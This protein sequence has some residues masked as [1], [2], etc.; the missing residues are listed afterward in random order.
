MNQ[1]LTIETPETLFASAHASV[2]FALACLEPSGKYLRAKSSFVDPSGQIMHWHDFGDLE[3]PGWAANAIGGAELLYRW[4]D[5]VQ[6][7]GS[8]QKALLLIDHIL[9][10]GFIQPD[11]F[12]YPYFDLGKQRFCLNYLHQD[13]WLCPGSLARIG[14]Q[15]LSLAD[16]LGEQAGDRPERL[17]SAAEKLAGWLEINVPL[18]PNGWIPRRITPDGDPYPLDPQG[19]LDPIFDHSADGLFLLQLWG[20]TGKKDLAGMLGDAFIRA[21]GYWGSINHDTFDDHENVAYAAAFRIFRSLAVPLDRPAW[22]DFALQTTLPSLARFRIHRDEHGVQTRGLYWMEESWDT[23]Y[24]WE[25]AEIALAH[26]E[27]WL[28]NGEEALRDAALETLTTISR[29]HYGTMGFL[30]EGVDWNNHVGQQHHIQHAYYG[31]IRY[32]EPLLNNLHL[33]APTLLYL[34]EIDFRPPVGTISDIYI[35]LH[36][37][38]FTGS[39]LRKMLAPPDQAGVGYL[40]RFFYPVLAS[41]ESV[42]AAIRFVADAGMDGVL[43]FETNYDT[44]PALVTLPVLKERFARLKAIVPRF[45]EAGFEVHI[46]VEICMGHVDAGGGKPERFDFQFQVNEDGAVSRSSAC[47]LDRRYLDYAAQIFRWAAECGASAVWVDDDTRFVLHDLPGMSCFCPLH[48]SAMAERSGREWTREELVAALKDDRTDPAIRKAWFDLQ[49]EAMTGL[50]RRVELEVHSVDPEQQ[51]GLMSIGTIYHS[52]EGRHTDRMLRVLAGEGEQPMLRPGSGFWSDWEP[53]NVLLKTEDVARQVHF[54]GK[55]V[56]LVAEIENHPYSPYLKSL[57]VLGLELALEVLAG[58]PELSFNILNSTMPLSYDKEAK[59]YPGGEFDYAA[60]LRQRKPFLDALAKARRGKVRVGIGV[61][62]NEE[63]ARRLPLRGRPLS[64]WMEPRPWE[65]VF[66][67][68]GLPV[69]TPQS[70]P[71]FL[72]GE[73]VST[74]DSVTI[75]KMVGEGVVMTPS[76]VRGLLE[77]GWGGWLG[78][79]AVEPAAMGVNEYFTDD[80]LNGTTAGMRLQVRHYAPQLNPYTYQVLAGTP[81]RIL[82]YWVDV[83]AEARGPA[84]LALTLDNGSRLGLLPFEI[85]T[86]PPA[87][88]QTGRRDQ[89][90]A[91]FEWVSG[92]PL[93]CRIASGVNLA[94]QLFLDEDLREGLLAV[95]N[96]SADDQIAHL[97]AP[98]MAGKK[99]ERLLENGAWKAEENPLRLRVPAWSLAA[100]RW[101]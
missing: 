55:D 80:P 90:T 67:R 50:M 86:L 51:V 33:V 83:D 45:E 77:K 29:H 18:L 43:L 49:E 21:G 44:D 35:R 22:M 47:P 17:R 58:T 39:A 5:Y 23:A 70:A 54:L 1:L 34:K 68:L 100:L 73:I 9:E 88:L 84:V 75:E 41:D 56:R 64:V 98:V 7:E 60:F 14:A 16:C 94:V 40:V 74:L 81:A 37:G 89:W 3:G 57:T 4:A 62:A 48:L 6:D 32:T 97:S 95:A 42:E 87:L 26:L 96:L 99:I 27:A 25:N 30:T 11:G 78:I 8:K 52:A 59:L 38:G 69:G 24:L 13:N 65:L 31:A 66:S 93:P 63:I 2:H 82:S 12:I 71:H 10:D 85:T 36:K 46:N 15:M 20:L 79:G 72:A 19:R 53:G 91:L 92:V 101:L 28:D 76:A 61:E